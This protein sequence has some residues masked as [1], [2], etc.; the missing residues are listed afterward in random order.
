MNIVIHA[1]VEGGDSQK[2]YEGD[3]AAEA[4]EFLDS[5]EGVTVIQVNCSNEV[6]GEKRA[7]ARSAKGEA[8]EGLKSDAVSWLEENSGSE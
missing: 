6:N 3:D 7:L 5:L 4:Q 2:V 8:A 1:E